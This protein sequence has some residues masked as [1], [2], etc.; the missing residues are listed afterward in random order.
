MIHK[1]RSSNIQHF[2]IFQDGG[3]TA[4][5]LTFGKCLYERCQSCSSPPYVILDLEWKFEEIWNFEKHGR[6]RVV[7]SRSGKNNE[8]Y[9]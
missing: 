8:S 5:I 6:G 1:K 3:H 7:S 9:L 4:E 2:D